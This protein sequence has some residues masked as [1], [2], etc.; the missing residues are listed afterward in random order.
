MGLSPLI[1]SAAFNILFLFQLPRHCFGRRHDA[2]MAA[3]SAFARCARFYAS[4]QCR[5]PACCLGAHEAFNFREDTPAHFAMRTQRKMTAIIDIFACA[6]VSRRRMPTRS[7]YFSRSHKS[8]GRRAAR[9]A[10]IAEG[11]GRD[12]RRDGHFRRAQIAADYHQHASATPR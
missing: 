3:I 4:Q 5:W 9:A 7:F 10:R 1:L 11:A 6:S 12:S 8:M 2:T